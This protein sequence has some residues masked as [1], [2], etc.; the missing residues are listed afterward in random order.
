MKEVQL[1]ASTLCEGA[2]N[3]YIVE[4]I[5]EIRQAVIDQEAD[6]GKG[7]ITITIDVN[8]D[9]GGLGA[10]ISLKPAKVAKPAPQ[11]K[12]QI[13]RFH[14]GTPVVDVD[15]DA[16]GNQKLFMLKEVK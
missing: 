5:D 12:G 11:N 2:L 14:G 3:A 15:E 13:V 10:R 8:I 4:A 6:N 9:A 16:L 7:T 1:D